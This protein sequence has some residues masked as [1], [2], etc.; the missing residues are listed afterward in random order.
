VPEGEMTK[1]IEDDNPNALHCATNLA[2]FRCSGR[3]K[4]GK[5][6]A[7]GGCATQQPSELEKGRN[8]CVTKVQNVAPSGELL[9]PFQS[10]LTTPRCSLGIHTAHNIYPGSELLCNMMFTL[11]S[12]CPNLPRASLTHSLP[13]GL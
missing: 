9:I 1:G 2:S 12:T 4:G 3:F 11:L 6:F 7:G 10:V 5:A 8:L 13:S